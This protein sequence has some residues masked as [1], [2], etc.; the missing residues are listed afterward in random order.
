M[1]E[2]EP[3]EEAS[4]R[5]V[6]GSGRSQC[7][8]RTCSLLPGCTAGPHTVH[9]HSCRV[10][11]PLPMV[12]A[13]QAPQPLAK[14]FWV[15]GVPW[16]ADSKA[17]LRLACFLLPCALSRPGWA[18]AEL[19]SISLGLSGWSP[20][21]SRVL[22]AHGIHLF[23]WLARKPPPIPSNP[24][25]PLGV[26]LTQLPGPAPGC[27]TLVCSKE[28]VSA[29]SYQPRARL[30][31]PQAHTACDFQADLPGDEKIRGCW[32]REANAAHAAPSLAASGIGPLPGVGGSKI[33]IEMGSDDHAGA[34]EQQRVIDRKAPEAAE[35]PKP[36]ARKA[37]AYSVGRGGCPGTPCPTPSLAPD[38]W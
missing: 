12:Q 1:P 32:R 29:Q 30:S 31:C 38:T 8:L 27:Q 21:R 26:P 14:R 10:W 7:P 18:Q 9:C 37:L 36:A 34:R 15:I 4:L 2:M 13:P 24:P 11:L 3:L 33:A 35:L 19:R 28:D 25:P 22:S 6:S 16:A 23:L 5:G 20:E 17:L